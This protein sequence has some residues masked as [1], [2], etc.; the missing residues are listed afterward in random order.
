MSSIFE[1]ILDIDYDYPVSGQRLYIRTYFLSGLD[2]T[3]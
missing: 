2:F 1:D 3:L